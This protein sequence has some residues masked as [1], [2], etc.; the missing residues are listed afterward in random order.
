METIDI[1][2]LCDKWEINISTTEILERW[3]EPWRKYHTINHLNDLIAQIK[4]HPDLDTKK[5]E[6]LYITAIFHDIVYK[7]DRNDNEFNSMYFLI[8]RSKNINKVKEIAKIILETIDHKATSPLSRIFLEM[9]MDIVKRNY[10][11]LLAWEEGITFE[12]N[13]MSKETYKRERIK[14]LEKTLAN[15]PTNAENLLRLIEY[16]QSKE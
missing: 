10:D 6:I 7:P 2:A 16:V 8:E 13:F 1:Q 12:Y 11:E 4:N 5:K 15:Y 3:S 14:F 9:D